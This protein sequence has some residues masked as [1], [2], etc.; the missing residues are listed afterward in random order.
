MKDRLGVKESRPLADFL[1]TLTIAAK[2]L[3]TEMTNYNVEEKD[4]QGETAITTEHV[5]NNTSV[6]EMLG[7]RGIKPENLPPSEDIKKLERRVKK[8]DKRLA[9]KRKT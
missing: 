2:K 8:E 1:P 3:A 6:R 7:Q 4:L 9:E 5:E